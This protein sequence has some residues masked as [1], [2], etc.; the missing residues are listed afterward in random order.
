MSTARWIGIVL[1]VAS[2]CFFGCG[3]A[4]QSKEQLADQMLSTVDQIGDVYAS[5]KDEKSAEAAKDKLASLIANLKRLT[6]EGK[7]LGDPSPE[8]KAKIDAELRLKTMQMQAK[9]GE[10]FKTAMSNP[11]IIEIMGPVM[12]EMAAPQ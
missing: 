3:G 1:V 5:I 8:L 4:E 11:R 2:T 7:Q 12:R 10:F 9:L 6:E